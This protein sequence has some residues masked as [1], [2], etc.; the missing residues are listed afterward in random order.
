M[1]CEDDDNDI[2]ER[3]LKEEKR[4][5]DSMDMCVCVVGDRRGARKRASEARE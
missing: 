3:E 1:Y 2:I 5:I 4:S